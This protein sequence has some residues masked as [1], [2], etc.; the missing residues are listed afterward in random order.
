MCKNVFQQ[1]SPW[2]G[3]EQKSVH[4]WNSEIVSG[5][6]LGQLKGEVESC[7]SDS[8]IGTRVESVEK[9]WK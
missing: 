2:T 5:V 3:S 1:F 8:W 4:N 9:K 7:S 6:Y